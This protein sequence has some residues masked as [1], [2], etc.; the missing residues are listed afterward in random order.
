VGVISLEGI[1]MKK[2]FNQDGLLAKIMS[3]S[4][5]L[6]LCLLAIMTIVSDT[7]Q[8]QLICT[9]SQITNATG[10][11][12][13]EP[14]INSNGTRITFESD[15]NLTG[16]NAD[17]NIEI[18][19]F[20]TTT[21]TLTQITNTTASQ[22]LNLSINSDGTRIT[23]ESDRNLTGNNADGN[24]EIILFDSTTDTL[25]QITNTTEGFSYKPSINSDGTRIAF[26]SGSDLTG[27][28]ADANGEIFLFDTTTDTFTQITNTTIGGSFAPSINSD[29]TRIAFGSG[30]DL[31]GNNADGNTEIFLFDTTTDTFTQITNTTAG[32]IFN[33]SINSDGTRII[34][35]SE[36]DLTGN[37]ADGN[38]EIFLFDTT[39]DTFTQITNTTAGSNDYPSTNSNGTRF[40]FHSDRD[41]IGNNA[42]GNTEIFLFDT[43]TDTFTQITN[44]TIGGSFAPSINSDGTRIAFHSYSDLTEN[45]ADGNFEIFLAVCAIDTD[46]DGI[47]DDLDNCPEI[48]NPDQSD[49]DGD[50]LGD[51]CDNCPDLSSP[52]QT[53]SDQDERGDLCDNCPIDQNQDQLDA[54]SDDVGD[55]CD[56]CPDIAN[57]NQNDYDNDGIGD[58]CD[59]CTDRDQDGYGNPGFPNNTCFLDNCPQYTNPNQED[60]DSD[61]VGNPCDNCPTVSN[62][63]QSNSDGDSFGDVC[64]NCPNTISFDQGDQDNDGVGD[65]CDNCVTIANPDQNDTDGDSIGNACDNC[66]SIQNNQSDSDG[67]S[68]GDLCDN[69]PSDPNPNQ[70][71]RDGDG[72]G[73]ECDICPILRI[74]GEGSEEV[75]RL[76]DFR[77]NVLNQTLEG[78]QLIEVYY[79]WSPVIVRALEEDE[80]FKEEIPELIDEILPLVQGSLE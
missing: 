34:F 36:K 26:E 49:T 6:V 22:N 70:L 66:P 59:D 73:D 41:L 35:A 72:K 51:D 39:T 24:I 16:N 11:G 62:A 32:L 80:K 14:A 17:G 61:R 54:D 15:R 44:T 56:S 65:V 23:F 60:T 42:D 67:D 74:F 8:A 58:V 47:P 79:K 2:Q 20:D 21:D 37:N 53:D 78:R 55:V 48:V 7:T 9:I 76:R 4:V 33:I 63:N 29:G 5:F 77:D 28:N 27:N 10:S 69:C 13:Y 31:T 30:S 40:A 25:T 1:K 38:T 43:T 46:G 3:R 19:L 68:V 18:F 12:S 64:D 57:L 75:Q 45:N 50:N 52:D 71:D